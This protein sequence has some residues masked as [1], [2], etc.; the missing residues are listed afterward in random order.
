MP[1][2]RITGP[3]GKVYNVTG[4]EG[5]TPEQALERV[6]AQASPK[7]ARPTSGNGV[8]DQTLSSFNEALMGAGEGLYNL[9]SG[10]TD[11]VMRMA[12]GNNAV[13]KAVQQRKD[14][15]DK[16]SRAVISRPSNAAR[17]TGQIASTIPLSALKAPAALGKAAPIVTRGL[18]GAA[19][20]LAVRNQGDSEATSAGIGAIA[21]MA[22][23][24]ILGAAANY[25]GTSR[26]VQWLGQKL[27]PI[28]GSMMNA[29][30]DV[31]GAAYDKLGPKVA[32]SAYLPKQTVPLKPSIPIT[33]RTSPLASL[34][35]EAEARAANFR[36]VGINNPTTGMVTRDPRVWTREREL[37]KIE[38]V[39]DN[40]TAR[41]QK[42]S[43][44]LDNA[45]QS[46]INNRGGAMGAEETGAA[47][48]KALDAKRTEMQQVTSS[49]YTRIRDMHG[50]SSAGALPS[51]R[52]AIDNAD[53]LDN[54]TF[55]AMREGIMRR[56]SRF[57]MA[58]QSGMLRNDSVAT[59]KQAEELRKF[60][61]GLGD[62][63]D[64][65]VRMMR[66]NLIDA[67][68]DDVV[69]GF[70]DD[71]FKQARAAARA[72]FDEFS[73]TFAG[74]VAD[75]A[76][77][78]EALTRRVLGQGTPLSDVRAL[79]KSLLSGTGDQIARGQQ[80]WDRIGA[81]ALDDLFSQSR[82]GELLSGAALAKN[83]AKSGPKL[84]TILSADDFKQ[85]QRIVA[86]ARDA[87][88]DVPFSAVNYSNTKSA[89]SNLF[90]KPTKEG[91]NIVKSALQHLGAFV[92]AGPGG[93]VALSVGKGVMA[94]AAM[95]KAA[96]EV[97]RQVSM[98][99]S[100][101]AAAAALAKIKDKALRD[102]VIASLV[103][104]GQ[105]FA[106]RA[107]GIAPALVN[108]PGPGR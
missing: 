89:L 72:R 73:K 40:L 85:L 102:A 14:V 106:G 34:G 17:V 28:A 75:E 79:K 2:F 43:Q 55:D 101:E 13:D 31:A 70:G 20:G 81:Q 6:K 25:I 24:P 80:A 105:D 92:T 27:A 47:V 46:L 5:S 97:E 16:A 52:Q 38:G 71:A 93:N 1:T 58:G 91:G 10:I 95:S 50:D 41:F 63:K 57:G 12:F 84:R 9:A 87:T 77:A 65:A 22:L 59:V 36:A 33:P 82:K 96:R 32:P 18:Q 53:M 104:R 19:G 8:I 64:P 69:A 83:F 62:G 54:P 3:D 7:M 74:K 107:P 51:F 49:L 66:K 48:Q 44:E 15:L 23:P 90:Q 26:P 78:P 98:A 86:A 4:P 42:V 35:P 39:G 61:G 29:V 94:D 56:M 88:T 21:N 99:A 37:Q 11:P 108:P 103:K 60:I 67:L 45:A 100:P 76:I 30:D 68:D